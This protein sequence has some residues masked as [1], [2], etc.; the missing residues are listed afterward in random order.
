MASKRTINR[1]VELMLIMFGV[2]PGISCVILYRVFWL[3]TLAINEFLHYQ[4]FVTHFHF[5]NLFNLMDCL[6]SFLAHVKLTVKLIIF[7]LKQRKFMEI[8]STMAEDWTDCD[9]GVALRETEIKAK[10]SSR[11][12]N[13]LIILHTI[14]ALAYV[15]GILLAD[16]DVTDRTAEL[17][18]MMK[19]EYPFTVDTQR[20]YRL[21]LATQF[22]FVVVCA[23]GA[24]L[25]NAL[26]LTLV[27]C[28][29]I[30]KYHK[31]NII[32]FVTLDA[33]VLT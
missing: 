27:T 11:I 25:F 26:F 15:I 16:A 19:M 12:C 10:L 13:G 33:D 28:I 31:Q 9:N 4:Y 1:T 23:W 24:A 32:K 2:W 8:L 30:S 21:V 5:D 7:S 29:Y 6:S 20:K 14:G 17:P 3:I 22:V 18:L